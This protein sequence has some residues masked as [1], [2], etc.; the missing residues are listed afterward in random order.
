MLSH[1][2]FILK[3]LKYTLLP[4]SITMI[5]LLMGM[6]SPLLVYGLD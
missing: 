3:V 5:S 1:R 4:I 6:V 2:D